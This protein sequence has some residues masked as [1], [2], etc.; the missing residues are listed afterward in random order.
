MLRENILQGQIEMK[1]L[2]AECL[3]M[4]VKSAEVPALKPHVVNI[5]GP[6]IRVLGDRYPA[7]VKLPIIETLSKL[8][9]KVDI[10]LR[11]FL[12]Q[13][14]STFIKALQDQT[15]RPVRLAAGGALARLLKL[16][17]KPEATMIELLKLLAT[18]PDHQLIESS[19]ATARALVA[20][21]APKI[22]AETIEEIYRVSEIIYTPAV[23]NPSEVDNSLTTCSGALLGET[24]ARKEDWSTAEK[25]VLA[26]GFYISFF[27]RLAVFKFFHENFLK[28]YKFQTSNRPRPPQEPVKPKQQ[29]S[30]KCVN[31]TL[32]VCGSPLPTLP[33]VRPSPPDSLRPIRS[34]HASPSVP[35]RLSF[36]K[37]ST[38]ICCPPS[39]VLS[40]T[41]LPTSERRPLRLSATWHTIRN[42][43]M[44]C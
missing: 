1:A 32:K 8:L 11:P 10:M 7:N 25:S 29:P 20:T 28:I 12:P 35:P 23:E 6:L 16:H 44:T 30:N 42:S 17:P 37:M 31:P 14:Q 36:K 38:E 3:G 9:D 4:V 13:L 34:S 26:G 24:I 40:T 22:S 15:S 2:A 5:T 39:P 21:C 43:P 19:L 27:E 41:P 18:S 33:V